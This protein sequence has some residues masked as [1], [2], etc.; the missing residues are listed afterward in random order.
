LDR[1]PARLPAFRPPQGNGGGFGAALEAEAP[2]A[3]L[4]GSEEL[5]VVM[6]DGEGG[7]R[8][9]ARV[10][11]RGALERCGALEPGRRAAVAV[12]SLLPMAETR[13]ALQVGGWARPACWLR[14]RCCG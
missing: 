1:Q 4:V 9:A 2:G 10:L 12:S 3:G 8:R 5:V 13:Q 14:R 11:A 6:L 7:A